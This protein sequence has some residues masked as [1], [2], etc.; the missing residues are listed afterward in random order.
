MSN[1]FIVVARERGEGGIYIEAVE[2]DIEE[3]LEERDMRI[4]YCQGISDVARVKDKI[5]TWLEDN[6]DFKDRHDTDINELI[7]EMIASLQWIANEH[8]LQTFHRQDEPS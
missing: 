1:G 8:P 7:A 5:N 4:I 2:D 3:Y 6:D